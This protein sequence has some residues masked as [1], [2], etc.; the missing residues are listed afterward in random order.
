M[1]DGDGP[2]GEGLIVLSHRGLLCLVMHMSRLSS[3]ERDQVSF[4]GYSKPPGDTGS[5]FPGRLHDM[6]NAL[7]G[8]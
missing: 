1:L 7:W 6:W 5:T 4:E 8:S 3:P 2:L